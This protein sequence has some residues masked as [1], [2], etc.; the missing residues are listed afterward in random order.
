M[1]AAVL[2]KN[3]IRAITDISPQRLVD[4]VGGEDLAEIVAYLK[5]NMTPEEL[6]ILYLNALTPE[7][8]KDA[9]DEALHKIDVHNDDTG[10]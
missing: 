6:V 7:N 10:A 5:E 9:I 8:L 3:W 1:V 4:E 2:G